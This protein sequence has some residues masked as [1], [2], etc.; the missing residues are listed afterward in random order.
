VKRHK[1]QL[2][3]ALDDIDH[4]KTKVK[5]PQTNG[6]C[7]R[8]QKTAL[9]EFY[10]VTFRRKIYWSLGELRGDLDTW[11]DECNTQR[12]YHGKRCVGKTAYEE[13]SAGKAIVQ[14]KQI[15]A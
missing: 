9:A 3:L 7:E 4:T 1:Y 14:E 6:I 13:L 2:Y 11:L 10:R 8:F 12:A 5:K 15:A